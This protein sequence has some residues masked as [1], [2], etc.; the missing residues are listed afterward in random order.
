MSA[1]RQRM[2]EEMR[3]RGLAERT[4]KT[5]LAQVRFLAEYHNKPPDQL[6]EGD[7]RAYFLYLTVE[8]QVAASTF[9]IAINAIK[10]FYEQVLGQ[11][12]T[13]L[14]VVR[15]KRE[16]RLPVVLSREEVSRILACLRQLHHRACLTAIY[17]CGLRLLEG[18]QLE[19]R[20]VDGDRKMLHVRQGKNAKD[21]YV[22]IPTATVD[23]L[24]DCWAVHRHPVLLFPSVGR[25]GPAADTAT[26][27]HPSTV[28][29]AFKLARDQ[30]GV[31]KPAT[32]HTLRHSYATH[33]LEAGVNIRIIQ[34][35]LG[36]TSI[37]TTMLYTHLTSDGEQHAT[38]A[39]ENLMAEMPSPTSELPW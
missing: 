31:Q 6:T 11:D 21:R 12:W 30:S 23:L 25:R 20:D 22:P 7:L 34:Q 4:Q 13:L 39:V 18:V 38:A 26:T 17:S 27:M 5:Y 16:K 28:Q 33:L 8:K 35:Y 29:K 2:L 9:N 1:L 24:R 32:V 14:G 15:P 19:V 37:R 10:F 3:L 36:H